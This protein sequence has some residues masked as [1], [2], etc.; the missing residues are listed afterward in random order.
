MDLMQ[1][2]KMGNEL[3]EKHQLNDWMFEFNKNITK[4]FGRC[5]CGEHVIELSSD[6]VKRNSEE[7]VRTTILHEIAHALDWIKNLKADHGLSW[8]QI[9]MEI[10]IPPNRTFSSEVKTFQQEIERMNIDGVT[11]HVGDLLSFP[12][13]PGIKKS[14]RG[15]LATIVEFNP[16]APKNPMFIKVETGSMKGREFKGHPNK[17]ETA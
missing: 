14:L 3:L 7:P 8:K 13:K 5:K 6:L 10:G 9:C 17:L 16:N 4:I 2:R 1:A 11:Y 12:D 15:E